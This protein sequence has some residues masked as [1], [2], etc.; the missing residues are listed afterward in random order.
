MMRFRGQ[1]FLSPY[2]NDSI[3][4]RQPF[5]FKGI[6]NC[7]KMLMKPKFANIQEKAMYTNDDD[8]CKEGDVEHM[9]ADE[10]YNECNSNTQTRALG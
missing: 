2:G 10:Q 8:T 3:Y 9:G 1:H 6:H 7:A 4:K 5:S